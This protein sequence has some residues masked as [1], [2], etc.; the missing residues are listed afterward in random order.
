VVDVFSPVLALAFSLYMQVLYIL[1]KIET[2]Q[3]LANPYLV[4]SFCMLSREFIPFKLLCFIV[5]SSADTL[6][7]TE[8]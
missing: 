2:P 3:V 4:Y 7:G 5:V 1:Y 8:N 6:L